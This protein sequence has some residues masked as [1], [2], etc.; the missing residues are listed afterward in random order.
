MT[1]VQLT[2]TSTIASPY[3]VTKTI[4]MTT[5]DNKATSMT[6]TTWL[7]TTTTRWMRMKGINSKATL[8]AV[9]HLAP[10]TAAEPS[11][12][13]AALQKATSVLLQLCP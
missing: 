8:M 10:V 6:M 1:V 3:S 5:L 13:C 11:E 12:R 9:I 4:S 2:L 7:R